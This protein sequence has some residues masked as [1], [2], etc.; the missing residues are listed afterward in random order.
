[1]QIETIKAHHVVQPFV[2]GPYRMSKGRVADAFDAVI[3]AITSN[4][5]I[6]GWGE[7]A[8]LGNFYA[9][10]FAAYEKLLREYIGTKQ[11]GA[12]RFASAFAPKTR[13]GLSFRNQ[14]IKMLTIPGVA[15]LTFGRDITDTLALPQYRWPALASTI[16]EGI[17]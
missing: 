15:R 2:D 17:E 4:S 1:M 8:P 14:V 13:W 16:H 6:T 5:G 11:Q 9:P 7:M 10:A 12:E 3:V